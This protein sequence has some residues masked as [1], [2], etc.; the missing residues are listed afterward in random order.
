MQLAQPLS[1]DARSLTSSTSCSVVAT[2]GVTLA[3]RWL[4]RAARIARQTRSG[5]GGMSRCRIPSGDNASITALTIAGAE[6]SVPGDRQRLIEGPR[7]VAGVVDRAGRLLVG[8]CV[9][10]NEVSATQLDRIHPQLIGQQIHYAF[11]VVRGL[12]PTG[13]P[14]SAPKGMGPADARSSSPDRT[15]S[16]PGSCFAEVVVIPFPTNAI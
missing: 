2:M 15:A 11:D 1:W 14:S 6:V 8:K 9:R 7:V 5:R 10:R 3:G 4:A 12:R 16:T 13:A